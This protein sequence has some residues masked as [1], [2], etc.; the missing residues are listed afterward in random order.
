MMKRL[1]VLL[2]C[3]LMGIG[4]ITAQTA[5]VTGRVTGSADGE[6]IV[7]ASV[8][9]K[10]VPSKGAATDVNGRFE[11]TGLPAEAKTLVISFIGMNTVEVPVAPRVVVE[12]EEESELLDDV[13]IVAYGTTKREAKT[14][15]VVSV[16]SDKITSLPASSI[17]KMLSGKL[18]GVQITSQS[19][20]P[21]SS[22]SIRIRGTSSINSGNEPLYVVDGIPVM[23]GDQSTFTNTNNAIAMI[24]P[25]DI[26]S[27]TVLKDAASASV[28]GSRAVRRARVQSQLVPSMVFLLWLMTITSGS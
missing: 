21:G 27:I 6:P 10:E 24:N 15:S 14:G 22:T 2:A 1:T 7:G 18:A 16:A 20:Q 13:V 11:L 23:N 8:A 3:I 25:D 4:S 5:R 17:D 12:L 28:Y 26:E 19:G 9:V